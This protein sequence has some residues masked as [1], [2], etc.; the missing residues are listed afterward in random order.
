MQRL[1]ETHDKLTVVSDQF[2]RPT[3][4]RTLAEFI[5]FIVE[6][7]AEYGT[8][9][10]SNDGSCSWYE[11]ANEIL[12]NKKVEVAPVTS[13]D[14]P[15]KAYRP[16]HSIM[17]LSKSKELGFIIPTWEDALKTFLSKLE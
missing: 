2:G 5:A 4:T 16:K 9:H 6:E 13:N 7:K 3:W 12:K 17:D 1:A 11:F 10:L 8:Y 15:Q 14:Y